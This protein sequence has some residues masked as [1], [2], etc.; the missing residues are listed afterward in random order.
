MPQTLA[1][2]LPYIPPGLAQAL[3][4]NPTLAPLVEQFPAAVLFA[5]ISGFTP[6]TE[7]LAQRGAEGP[8]E[9]T[10][11]LN[12][13]FSRLIAAIAAEGGEV[14]KFSGDALTALFPATA[15]P[16]GHATRRA[17]QAAAA[18]HALMGDFA[19]LPTSAGPIALAVKIGV[20]VGIVYAFRVGGELE[21][22]EYVV[23]GDPLRQVAEAEHTA[24]PGET[25]ISPEAAAVLASSTTP[26]ALPPQPLPAPQIA[27]DMNLRAVA[28]ALRGFIPGAL[29]VWIG[30]GLP[31]WLAEL[32]PM[33]LLFIGVSGLDYGAPNALERLQ[34]FLTTS[35]AVIYHYEGSLNKL[36]V[37][38][39]GTILLAMFGAPPLAHADDAVRAVQTAR[40]LLVMA[41][42]QGLA[43]AIGVAT[44]PVF[45]GPVGSTNRREYTVMGDAVNSAARLM[46]AAGPGDI[47]CDFATAHDARRVLAFDTLPPVRLKGKAGLIQVYRPTGLARPQEQAGTGTTLVGRQAELARLEAALDD[48]QAGRQRLLLIEGEAGMGKSRLMEEL[49][50]L[51]HAHGLTVL[52]SAGHSSERQ[53][54]YHAWRAIFNAY[55]ELSGAEAP[56]ERRRLVHAH[57]TEIAPELVERLPLLNDLFSIG[58]PETDLTAA[59]ETERRYQGREALLI[60]LLRRWAA[61]RP[62]VLLLDDAHWI[63]TCS[64]GLAL[65]VASALHTANLPLL[66]VLTMHPIPRLEHPRELV[67]LEALSGTE[68]IT[69]TALSPPDIVALAA[70]SLGVPAHALP[71]AMA[72]LVRSRA[73]GNPFFAEE[74]VLALRDQGVLAVTAED[75]QCYCVLHGDLDA[76]ARHLPDTIQGVVLSRI[77]R[78]DP[79]EQMLLR[80]GAVIGRSFPYQPLQAALSP[81][82]ALADT[83]LRACLERL[84][85]LDLIPQETPDPNL[86]HVFKNA[87]TREVAYSTMLF[88]QRRELHR[89]VAEWYEAHYNLA[90]AGPN[91]GEELATL[92]LPRTEIIHL[93]AYHYQQAGDTER[94]RRYAA[95]AGELA[96]AGFANAEALVYLNRALALTSPEARTERR[97]LV[98]CREQVHDVLA[99]RL[100]QEADIAALSD[101]SAADDMRAQAELALRQANYQ[102]VTDSFPRAAEAAERAAAL[103]H[104]VGWYEGEAMARRIH[105]AAL[106]PLAHYDEACT[107]L[108]QALALARSMSL[109]GTEDDCLRDLGLIAYCQGDYATARRYY[110]QALAIDQAIGDRRGE[111]ATLVR[112]GAVSRELGDSA[113][114]LTCY[115]QA[116]AIDRATGDRDDEADGLRGIGMVAYDRGDYLAARAAYTASLALERVTGDRAGQAACLA[117]LGMVARALGDFAAAQE[118]LDQAVLMHQEIGDCRYEAVVHAD[119]AL[120][121]CQRGNHQAAREQA[122]RALELASVLGA[123]YVEGTALARLGHAL[124][125]LADLQ[126]AESAYQAALRLSRELGVETLA[127]EPL[128]GLARL[129]L[130]S[131]D[132]ATARMQANELATALEA[133]V[134]AAVDELPQLFLSCYHVL[135]ATGDARAAQV[136]EIA[137]ARLNRQASQISD[138]TCRQA[139]WEDVPTHRALLAA[140]AI[141]QESGS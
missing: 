112:L 18:M 50:A 75:G 19:T 78:L 8:E 88:A 20:G 63:D 53:I 139:F 13:Y 32:R 17:V 40:D 58:F 92:G 127:L 81:Y 35:Q 10:R 60:E 117:A 94:E 21:R 85:F 65:A 42:A 41:E 87:I 126:G 109:A 84:A 137:R 4:A 37:D 116:L 49:T 71:T 47:R 67:A 100:A 57:I 36:A 26:S 113:T 115:E 15:D 131:G 70:I 130:A 7:T 80:V 69:L 105:G 110:E 1:A 38:D 14:V 129:A 119:L 98:L 91:T 22:W 106:I 24:G 121:Y 54:P 140:Y 46:A 33:S 132:L 122:Q 136:L 56:D 51:C 31:E 28:T 107:Q 123:R 102:L 99:D 96:A 25:I 76:A 118:A 74:I 89:R 135:F 141:A 66:M 43:M 93:L 101:L 124:H 104:T 5:D 64:W 79:E 90:G 97:R 6:L 45:A 3:L 39:K 138:A 23:A 34:D 83:D 44:G 73:D 62:L 125:G 30:E 11:L 16:A 133:E 61:E 55:F 128:A 120:L 108:G 2:M 27:P 29:R 52:A 9:M 68:K 59:L 95:L 86:C 103:A 48:V 114:A 82:L 77:D 111:S 134:I 72:E 12:A